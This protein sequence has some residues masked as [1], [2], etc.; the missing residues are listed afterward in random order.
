MKHAI[1]A[2]CLAACVAPA[3]APRRGV[4]IIEEREPLQV[5]PWVEDAVRAEPD[6]RDRQTSSL[7]IECG[8]ID[9]SPDAG[10]PKKESSP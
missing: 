7:T 5:R 8:L 10:T 2:L 6:S 9:N 3:P 1:V 4:T